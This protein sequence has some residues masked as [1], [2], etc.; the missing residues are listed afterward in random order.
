MAPEATT[1]KAPAKVNI[2]LQIR[3][4]RPDGYHNIH[5]VFQEL[6]FHDTVVISARDS[7]FR[8]EANVP[9]V[10]CDETNICYKIYSALKNRI[11][12]L[13][14]VNVELIKRIPAGAGLGGGSS[15]GAAVLKGLNQ[16]YQLDLSDGDLEKLS[17]PVGADIPFFIRGGT[18]LGDGIGDRLTPLPSFG[19][20]RL[21]LVIPDISIN[22]GWAYGESKKVLNPPR[23]KINFRGF[24][25][26]IN[27][28]WEL[29]ENDF[30]RIVIPAYPE[31]GIIKQHLREAGAIF[32]SLSGS[33]STVFGVFDDEA[34]ATAAESA[35]KKS[36]Q[37]FLTRPPQLQSI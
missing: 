7:G 4:R 24:F 35:L 2:G 15:D 11:S 34:A 30:E 33:G 37:T 6:E 14:G 22:T 25:Q 21:L 20:A 8:L 32:A 12:D 27:S 5:T 17:A 19:S 1:F 31:I 10:P 36:Y 16:L 9:W 29:F 3:E 26:G 28:S 23:E 13:P 18:Q